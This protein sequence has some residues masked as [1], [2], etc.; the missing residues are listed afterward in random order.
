MELIVLATIRQ[1]IKGNPAA[2]R[3]VWDRVDGKVRKE[4]GLEGNADKPVAIQVEWGSTPE[5]LKH[6]A[7]K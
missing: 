6:D 4:I 3:E 1:A 7:R 2:L 5:W